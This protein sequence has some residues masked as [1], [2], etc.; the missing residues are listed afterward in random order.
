MAGAVM[1]D[2][3]FERKHPRHPAGSDQGGEF[4]SKG[5]DWAQK[6]NAQMT[7]GTAGWTPGG[8][9]KGDPNKAVEQSK[10]SMRDAADRAV[11]EGYPRGEV[12]RQL[13]EII[14][15]MKPPRA[16]YE[17]GDH[18]II[19]DT[20]EQ[21]D[22]GP[23]LQLLDKLATD[24]PIPQDRV[25]L[26]MVIGQLPEGVGGETLFPTAQMTINQDSFSKNPADYGR[27][28]HF[29]PN[30]RRVPVTEW[31]ITHEWG[32]V[33]TPT[34]SFLEM[35]QTQATMH[36][37]LWRMAFKNQY[38]DSSDLDFWDSRAGRMPVYAASDPGE[39]YAE[40]FAEWVTTGGRTNNQVVK[41]YAA[42]YH[43]K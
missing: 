15:G 3:D 30:Q 33:I 29:Y 8:W 24:Y 5:P 37:M 35:A 1:V 17:N 27:P 26:T 41:D 19:V 31:V 11:A 38:P 12:M 32:H 36:P 18:R 9:K 2:T 22:I 25:P 10:K 39:A 7:G 21:F 23:M 42:R 6:L 14:G 20:D 43:W 13:R 28:G 16:F 34:H 4:R 40:A